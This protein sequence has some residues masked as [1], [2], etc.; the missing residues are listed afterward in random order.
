ML[1]L[2][3]LVLTVSAKVLRTNIKVS[4]LMANH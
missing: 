2:L 4:H 3:L 1:S